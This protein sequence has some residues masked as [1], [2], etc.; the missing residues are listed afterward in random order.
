[1]GVSGGVKLLMFGEVLVMR[2]RFCGVR[3]NDGF[4]LFNFSLEIGGFLGDIILELNEDV[5]K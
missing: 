3:V 1:M 2:L 4:L 5:E